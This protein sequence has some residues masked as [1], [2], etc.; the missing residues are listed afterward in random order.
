MVFASVFRVG[1]ALVAVAAMAAHAAPEEETGAPRWSCWYQGEPA[2]SVACRLAR[3]PGPEAI[4]A[5]VPPWMERMP[6]VVRRIRGDPGSLDGQV[7]LIPLHAP[8]IDMR[9][10][11][12]LARGVMCGAQAACQVEFAPPR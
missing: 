8:P 7:I 2:P 9:D 12:R 6:P 5:A 4:P 1:A 11:G 3:A 10:A